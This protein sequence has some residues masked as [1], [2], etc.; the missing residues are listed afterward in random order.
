MIQ[1]PI[2]RI[3]ADEILDFVDFVFAH[4]D[5]DYVAGMEEPNNV[6]TDL[7]CA[8]TLGNFVINIPDDDRG[9]AALIQLKWGK[10]D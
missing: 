4:G 9:F 10:D 2:R 8:V 7:V 5:I 1:I 6:L 3:S